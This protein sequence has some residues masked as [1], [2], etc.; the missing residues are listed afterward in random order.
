MAGFSELNLKIP[1]IFALSIFMSIFN[2]MLG[3]VEHEK[4]LKPWRK[5]ALAKALIKKK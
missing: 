5:I 4:S 2:F 1:S 3:R